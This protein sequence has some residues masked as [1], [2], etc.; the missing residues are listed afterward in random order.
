MEYYLFIDESG[1]HGLNTIDK[2][3]PV[4]TLCGILISE[5]HYKVL[6]DS[7]KVFKAKFWG[8]KKVIL[9]SSDIRKC[10]NEFQILFNIELK[11]DFY[12]CLNTLIT[13][14]KYRVI[15]ASVHKDKY[16]KKYGK[17][18]EG[19]YEISL[20]Y[21]IERMV[22]SMDEINDP[23]KKVTILIEKRGSREDSSLS[24][25]LQKIIARG[26]YYVGSDRIR[27]LIDSYKFYEKKDDVPG[28]QLADLIAYP[29]SRY[30][31]DQERANPAFDVL[32]CKIY[33]KG[34]KRYGL[35]IYP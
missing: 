30:A 34:G 4:F 18:A 27:N 16:I 6:T 22:F 2:G 13:D 1:D 26:T 24:E 35:K 32:E 29:I 10:Q 28:L 19:V 31:I 33:T 17:V 14:N 21:I 8:N 5:G 9:H 15:A 25:Y 12:N 7:M 11:A 3:F 20:S 23:N